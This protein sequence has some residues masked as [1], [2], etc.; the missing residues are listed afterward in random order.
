MYVCDRKQSI[1]IYYTFT[2]DKVNT[3]NHNISINECK[4]LLIIRQALT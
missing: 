3:N 4:R 2:I 1:Q